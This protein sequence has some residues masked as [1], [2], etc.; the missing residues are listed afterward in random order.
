MGNVNVNLQVRA[1]GTYTGNDAASRQISHNLSRI[2]QLV[3]IQAS[4]G[5][6][7]FIGSVYTAASNA[8][9]SGSGTWTVN[10][11]TFAYFCVGNAT[12][13]A[14]S[15]NASGVDYYWVAI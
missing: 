2:P 7:G 15:A 13:Y 11:A 9:T 8:I 10:P 4:T 1:V 5:Q 3:V 12:S 14:G 6:V